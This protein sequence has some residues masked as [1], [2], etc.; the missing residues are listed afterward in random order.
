MATFTADGST[1]Y[2]HGTKADFR[3]GDLIEPGYR[4]NFGQRRQARYVY[5]TA[6][7]DAAVWG[8]SWPRETAPAASTSW[9]PRAPSRT[10]PT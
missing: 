9:S 7:L 8:R 6:T 4:S 1:R 2:Y 3:P 10:T 5:L